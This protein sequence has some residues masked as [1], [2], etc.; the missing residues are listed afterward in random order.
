ME[1]QTITEG[2]EQNPVVQELKRFA[3]LFASDERI[4]KKYSGFGYSGSIRKTRRNFRNIQTHTFLLLMI[5]NPLASSHPLVSTKSH[6]ITL[7]NKRLS[8]QLTPAAA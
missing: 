5:T 8:I 2:W 7:Q 4:S 1:P 3:E 6:E